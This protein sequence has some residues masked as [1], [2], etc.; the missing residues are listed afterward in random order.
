MNDDEILAR[1]WESVSATRATLAGLH[2]DAPLQAI[3]ARSQARRVRRLRQGLGGTA[4]VTAVATLAL[5]LPSGEPGVTARQVHVNLAAWSVNTTPDGTVTFAMRNVSDPARL[6]RVLARAGVPALVR[7]GEICQPH[8]SPLPTRGIIDPPKP[9]PPGIDGPFILNTGQLLQR[10]VWVIHPSKI[11]HGT[12]FILSEVTP[13]QVR[14]G[15]IQGEW[16]RAPDTARVTCTTT[17][18]A[19]SGWPGWVTPRPRPSPS[20]TPSVHPSPTPSVHPSASPTPTRPG[21]P[22]PT[23][24]RPGSPTPTRTRPGSPSPTPTRPVLP[25]PTP[26]RQHAAT[27]TLT[28]RS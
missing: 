9:L 22:S 21:S 24:T 11:P 15:H 16:I 13:A 4:A 23:P 14:S 8:R 3:L 19:G 5:T 6:Q 26:T 25:T 10:L 12:R 18:P 20:P 17:P 27:P 7:Y 1:A 28:Q 2:M